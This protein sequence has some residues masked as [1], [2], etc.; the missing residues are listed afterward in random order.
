[1]KWLLDRFFLMVKY[2]YA[3]EN[4]EEDK[5]SFGQNGAVAPWSCRVPLGDSVIIILKNVAS[6]E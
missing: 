2:V 3:L 6:A 5:S 1:M 4:G